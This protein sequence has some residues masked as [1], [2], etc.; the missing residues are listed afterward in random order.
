MIM[1][2][3]EHDLTVGRHGITVTITMKDKPSEEGLNLL[4][5]HVWMWSESQCIEATEVKVEA[6]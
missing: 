5:R 1:C 3:L 6:K 2:S 4:R